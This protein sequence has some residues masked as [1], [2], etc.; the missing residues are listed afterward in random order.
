MSWLYS[1]VRDFIGLV[2]VRAA[3]E[4]CHAL[5]LY[6]EKWL[7]S[8]TMGLVS[9]RAALWT[10]QLPSKRHLHY[11][12]LGVVDGTGIFN[13]A[14]SDCRSVSQGRVTEGQW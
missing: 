1:V 6:P 12:M 8:L 7:A 2:V 5:G 13:L 10:M 3:L 11:C 14:G 4:V 9:N